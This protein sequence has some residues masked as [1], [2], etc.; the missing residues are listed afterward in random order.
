[1]KLEEYIIYCPWC[2]SQ[3]TLDNA[4]YYCELHTHIIIYRCATCKSDWANGYKGKGKTN[5]AYE[6]KNT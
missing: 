2:G 5:G 1:M 4:E 6:V 3:M